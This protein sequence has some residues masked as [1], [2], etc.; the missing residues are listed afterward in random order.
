MATYKECKFYL[1]SGNCIHRDAPNPYHSW[2]IGK[3]E[4]GSWGDTL[5]NGHSLLE[6]LP[7]D[8]D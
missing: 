3:D 6:P 7:A 5:N 8:K 4:C 2:C 1:T